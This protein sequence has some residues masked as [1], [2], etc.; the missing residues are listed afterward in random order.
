MIVL[1]RF[2][3]LPIPR[4]AHGLLA[5][6]TNSRLPPPKF[7]KGCTSP[8]AMAASSFRSRL[9]KNSPRCSPRGGFALVVLYLAVFCL[10]ERAGC[11]RG[12]LDSSKNRA[13]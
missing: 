2:L 5:L 9:V 12:Y 11:E 10:F 7:G 4:P 1:I 6:S 13:A 3:S 8:L